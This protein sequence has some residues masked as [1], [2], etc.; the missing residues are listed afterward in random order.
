MKNK[1]LGKG[2]AALLGE[3]N[4]ANNKFN[5]GEIVRTLPIKDIVPNDLQPRKAFNEE[6]LSDLAT[7]IKEHGII[8]PIIVSKILGTQQYKIVAG[9]RRWRAAKLAGLTE[10]QAIVRDLIGANLAEKA[11]IENIQREDLN[12]IDES[13]AYIELAEKHGYTQE[14]LAK[15]LGKNRSHIANMMRLALLPDQVKNYIISG[16][17][18]FSH[19]K[20]IAGNENVLDLAKEIVAK[21]LSVRQTEHLAKTGFIAKQDPKDNI[22]KS[23]KLGDNDDYK[24][25]SDDLTEKLGLRCIIEP[26]GTK[27]KIIINY[28]NFVQL[29]NVIG[30]LSA[31]KT[32]GEDR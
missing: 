2:L 9:E 20:V 25:I 26:N 31:S 21:G 19:A 17:I 30:L 8:Q 27:G 5:E 1:G 28:N 14:K 23:K 32:S 22:Q 24:N 13:Q 18:S 29:D 4:L 11:L 15:S 12:P 10:I 7:S 3:Q 16:L 6:S